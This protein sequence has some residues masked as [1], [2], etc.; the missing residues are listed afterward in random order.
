M[1][2]NGQTCYVIF[3]GANYWLVTKLPAPKEGADFIVWS[4]LRWVKARK[5]FSQ[6]WRQFACPSVYQT[7]TDREVV[8][9]LGIP[10]GSVVGGPNA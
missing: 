8:D 3:T 5:G 6:K 10:E 2:C 1:K 9:Q 7:L 4:G